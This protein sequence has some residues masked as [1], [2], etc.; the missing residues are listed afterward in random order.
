MIT[1]KWKVLRFKCEITEKIIFIPSH[2]FPGSAR[3]SKFVKIEGFFHDLL[4]PNFS[5]TIKIYY[6]S[7]VEPI[8]AF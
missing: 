3:F 8:E 5:M 2:V 1:Y 7:M 6:S 4:L